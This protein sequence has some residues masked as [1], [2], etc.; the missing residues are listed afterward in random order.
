MD[1]RVRAEVQGICQPGHHEQ[2]LQGA[3]KYEAE[4]RNCSGD[5]CESCLRLRVGRRGGGRL[6]R[7]CCKLALCDSVHFAKTGRL[8]AAHGMIA[9][10]TPRV[11]STKTNQALQGRNKVQ[12]GDAIISSNPARVVFKRSCA[13]KRRVPERGSATRSTS[14]NRPSPFGCDSRCLRIQAALNNSTFEDI[15]Q[16]TP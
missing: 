4:Q 16:D 11:S 14:S 2:V 9:R 1:A 10:A 6:L 3:L 12:R 13:S 7:F 8:F 15:I 5:K